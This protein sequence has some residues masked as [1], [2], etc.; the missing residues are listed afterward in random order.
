MNGRRH[1]QGV[2]LIEV[3]VTLLILS[4][5]LI[6][7]TSMQN[8]SLQFNQMAYFRSQAN[9]LAYDI[10]D[11]IRI[12]KSALNQNSAAYNVALA[13]FAGGNVPADATQA[14]IF[15]WRKAIGEVIPN[16]QGAI[17]CVNAICTVTIDWNEIN[18]TLN[19]SDADEKSS[20]FIYSARL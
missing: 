12:N 4:T 10:L 2:G 5:S 16:G 14:D 20:V 17:N 8:R 7:L 9:I 11:R 1:Q 13:P 15:Q 6:T 18:S 19:V 3:L